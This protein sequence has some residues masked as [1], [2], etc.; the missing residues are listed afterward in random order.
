MPPPADYDAADDEEFDEAN[1]I[2]DD[3]DDALADTGGDDDDTADEEG[4]DLVRLELE[5]PR[6][7]G[8]GA[9]RRPPRPNLMADEELPSPIVCARA[10]R[11]QE[12]AGKGGEGAPEAAAAGQAGAAGAHADGT[13]GVRR[14]GRGAC[15]CHQGAARAARTPHRRAR[16]AVAAPPPHEPPHAGM[17]RAGGPCQAQAQLPAQAGRDLP[18]LCARAAQ[19]QPEEVRAFSRGAAPGHREEGPP[20]CAVGAREQ[21]G[22]ASRG[23][24]LCGGRGRVNEFFCF[25]SLRCAGRRAGAW[26]AARWRTTRTRSCSRTRRTAASARAT[27]S[28]CSPASSRAAR[29]ASTRCRASTGSSTS[30]TTASTASW[31][32]RWCAVWRGVGHTPRRARI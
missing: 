21:E 18:A 8:P 14:R 5:R 16:L 17:A 31:P 12:G 6:G 11:V 25:A 27:A 24:A 19:G 9:T 3:A 13:G 7:L 23:G 29:S 20:R 15:A 1:L 26:R 4:D 30:T 22:R 10:A 28:R 32:T 2:A